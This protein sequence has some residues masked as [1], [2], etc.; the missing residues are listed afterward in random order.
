MNHSKYVHEGGLLNY[1]DFV[2]HS[3]ELNLVTREKNLF[4]R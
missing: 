1:N 2:K 3:A 4:W